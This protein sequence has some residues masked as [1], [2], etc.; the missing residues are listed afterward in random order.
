L[1]INLVTSD[2]TKCSL[3]VEFFDSKLGMNAEH[4]FWNS[5]SPL[6]CEQYW[7]RHAWALERLGN[8]PNLAEA[9]RNLGVTCGPVAFAAISGKTL[10]EAVK[11][12]ASFERSGWTTRTNME[13]ALHKAKLPFTRLPCVWPGAGL[14][15][16]QFTGPWTKRQ[17]AQAALKH[18]HWV[19]VFDQYVFDVNWGGWLPQANWQDVVLSEI[20]QSR[21]DADGWEVLTGYEMPI[22]A[23]TISS[24]SETA[25]FELK[26]PS[27]MRR[28]AALC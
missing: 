16:I 2:A 25:H 1:R 4:P 7:L 6:Q 19:A 23:K 13:K 5:E 21:P 18:T 26:P 22:N 14:C 8:I 10:P 11:C 9:V 12:F 3:G 20:L 17:F 28:T 27:A 15:L 24:H